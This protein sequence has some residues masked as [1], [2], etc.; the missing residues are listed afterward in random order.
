VRALEAGRVD[1]TARAAAVRALGD[2]L[3]KGLLPE[4]GRTVRTVLEEIAPRT[5]RDGLVADP[6]LRLPAGSA[7]RLA[8]AVRDAEA[9]LSRDAID[10]VVQRLNAHLESVFGL[11]GISRAATGGVGGPRVVSR[12]DQPLRFLS[13]WLESDPY[14]TRLDLHRERGRVP[15]AQPS[16]VESRVDR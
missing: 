4:S 14:F 9:F 16:R 8:A 2:A 10:A 6:A 3:T 12:E 1:A 5:V 15:A 11:D 13:G 7:D